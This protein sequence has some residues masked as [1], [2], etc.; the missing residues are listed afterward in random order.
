MKI[1]RRFSV[2]GSRLLYLAL[3]PWLLVCIPLFPY[4]A[5]TFGKSIHSI[6]LSVVISAICL[7][8]LFVATDSWRFIKVTI[9]LLALVPVVYLW[10]FCHVFFG[11]SMALTPS[12]RL[13]DATPFSAL[14]G[15]VFWGLPAI[16][17]V[18]SLSRKARRIGAVEA[19]R[20]LRR[21]GSASGL[22]PTR[23]SPKGLAK[24]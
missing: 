2:F 22:I 16:I 20:R 13:S 3:A 6:L 14:A 24:P 1:H 9:A 18:R 7:A 4:M 5:F 19:K 10:Y 23:D 15:G 8:G 12:L 21:R 11:E 17:G